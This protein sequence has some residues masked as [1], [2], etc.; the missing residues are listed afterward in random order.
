MMKH[1]HGEDTY[2]K[3]SRV[4]EIWMKLVQRVLERRGKEGKQLKMMTNGRGYFA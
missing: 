3:S 4:D 2:V 1:L